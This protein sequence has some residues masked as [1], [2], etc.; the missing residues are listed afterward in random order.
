MT[1]DEVAEWRHRLAE[2]LRDRKLQWVLDEM[3]QHLRLG[4]LNAFFGKVEGALVEAV[5]KVVVRSG[6]RWS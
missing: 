5:D 3:E 1:E 2:D 6:R 4:R